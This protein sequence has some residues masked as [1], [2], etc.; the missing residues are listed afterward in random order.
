M[1]GIIHGVDGP[2][3]RVHKT[4]DRAEV[5]SDVGLP[6]R[7][8]NRRRGVGAS[9]CRLLSRW[10][11]V[12]VQTKISVRLPCDAVRVSEESQAM[13]VDVAY[14]QS[15]VGAELVFYRDVPLL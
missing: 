13:A 10:H 15:G 3:I 7:Q 8:S 14:A 6:V 2:K 4:I 11:Q 9:E 5:G 1:A 12:Q